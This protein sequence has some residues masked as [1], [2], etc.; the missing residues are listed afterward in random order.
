IHDLRPGLEGEAAGADGDDRVEAADGRADRHAAEP[1]LGDRRAQDP[2]IEFVEQRLHEFLMQE[3]AEQPAADDDDA[4]VGAHEIAD[5][6]D[7]RFAEG[8][9]SHDPAP[10]AYASEDARERALLRSKTRVN[11][12]LLSAR[13]G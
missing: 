9:V 10:E 2:G 6:L 8:D 11:A 3:A 4:L 13:H 1:E 5:R 12:L 7:L